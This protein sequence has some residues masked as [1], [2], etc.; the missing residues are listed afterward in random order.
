MSQQYIDIE[1]TTVAVV[2]TCDGGE[3]SALHADT[4]AY[5]TGR[6]EEDAVEAL[7]VSM[8]YDKRWYCGYASDLPVIGI[9]AAKRTTYQR[10]FHCA[11]VEVAS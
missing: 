5:G 6:T 8:V 11:P 1:G 3:W 2:V 4:M 9:T 10:L 7:R